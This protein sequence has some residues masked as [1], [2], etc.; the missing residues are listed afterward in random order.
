MAGYNLDTCERVQVVAYTA[1]GKQNWKETKMADQLICASKFYG[2]PEYYNEVFE[3]SEFE[4]ELH[5][6]SDDFGTE[7]RLLVQYP[8]RLYTRMFEDKQAS[9]QAYF[10]ECESMLDFV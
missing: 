3:S 1:Q 9:I 2:R 7:Y 5:E 10:S 8:D 6:L 4:L